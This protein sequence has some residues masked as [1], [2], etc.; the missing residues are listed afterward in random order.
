MKKLN[1]LFLI[2]ILLIST[3][4][5]AQITSPHE[6]MRSFVI[7]GARLVFAGHFAPGGDMF[8]KALNEVKDPRLYTL[9]FLAAKLSGK[10]KAAFKLCTLNPPKSN[11]EHT[12]QYWC[13]R[14]YWENN[15]KKR[16]FLHLKRAIALGG[17]LNHYIASGFY[18]AQKLKKPKIASAYFT[19]LIK[20]DPW[21]LKTWM[22][23]N[24]LAGVILTIEDIFSSYKFKG[25]VYYSLASMAWNAKFPD[26]ADYFLSKAFKLY[27]S[28]FSGL[29]DL[30]LR[31]VR[32]YGDPKKT[33]EQLLLALKKAP[34]SEFLGFMKSDI[35][36]SKGKTADARAVMYRLMK[37]NPYSSILLT[38]LGI[39]D[40]DIGHTT[41]AKKYFGYA[42]VRG[43]N[44]AELNYGMGIYNQKKGKIKKALSYLK[45][46]TLREPTNE[47]YLSAYIAVLQ[48]MGKYKDLQAS[49]KKLLNLHKIKKEIKT[50]ENTYKARISK[51]LKI[52]TA[53]LSGATPTWPPQCDT[54][55][56]V[57]KAYEQLKKGQKPNLTKIM[58][59]ITKIN[60]FKQ[61]L[62]LN[63]WQKKFTLEKTVSI[64]IYR[65]FYSIRPSI[66][67]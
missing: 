56:Q 16:A 23:P 42:A 20:S 59:S 7:Q 64:K 54:Q 25:G 39:L 45:V 62:P 50:V 40:L 52:R 13:S 28:K 18:M 33:E 32:T 21:I 47:R 61:N 30:K 24:Y 48:S 65:F 46:S 27:S 35:L 36:R 2:I 11:R 14:I 34:R 57:F 58:K 31:I 60:L 43:S 3:R 37:Q 41:S 51:L 22:Y 10:D 55:C 9:I 15:H 53:I 29:Y 44:S 26:L 17:N 49:K 66:F 12:F 6:K 67:D 4:A 19:K 63:G 1:S 5:N 38:R 8:T